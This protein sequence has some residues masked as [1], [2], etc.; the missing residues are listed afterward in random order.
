MASEQPSPARR[1]VA[2]G[3]GELAAAVDAA[4]PSDL[5]VCLDPRRARLV[6]PAAAV[7]AAADQLDEG[8]AADGESVVGRAD[9]L[10]AWLAAG[11]APGDL[12]GDDTGIVFHRLRGDGATVVVH[13]R[14]LDTAA[15][16]EPV[17]AVSDDPAAL[18]ALA[19]ELA[20]DGSR[21]LA[22]LLRYDDAIAPGGWSEVGP[23]LIAMA[24]WTPPFCATIIRAAEAT[25]AFGADPDDP[26]PGHELSLA[27]ISPRLFA[28][29]ED[30]IALR[31]MPALQR[32]WPAIE[33]AGLRDAFVI[34]FSAGGQAELPLHHDV[35]QVSAS[36]RLNDGYV[37]GALEFPRQA[38]TNAA[39][40]VGT[41][42]AWPSL[43]THPHRSAPVRHGVKYSLTVWFELPQQH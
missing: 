18:E 20:D 24:F 2:V 41:L 4:A 29:V 37:G 25:G 3:R 36:V 34:K 42:L 12:P 22:R 23:E 10:A 17:V 6:A 32:T 19:T 7:L 1:V 9:V 13:G 35:A 14:L 21:D 15:G 31:V 43:V 16:T 28:H 11:G 39:T 33:Y 5:I 38:F 30:D 26:V 8:A 40:P 27:A